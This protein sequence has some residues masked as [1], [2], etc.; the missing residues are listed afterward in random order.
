MAFGSGY[1]DKV[2][3]SFFYG[4][5]NSDVKFS[6]DPEERKTVYEWRYGESVPKIAVYKCDETGM[7][8][9][10]D[11]TANRLLFVA[12][13]EDA[14]LNHSLTDLVEVFKQVY[15]RYKGETK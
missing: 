9:A 7:W 3:R 8:V 2:V 5:E 13:L 4:G 15:A 10:Y 14:V 12:D 11:V 6:D 1:L